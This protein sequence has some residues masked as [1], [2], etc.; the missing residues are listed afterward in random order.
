MSEGFDEELERIKMRMV[1]EMLGGKSRG[2]ESTHPLDLTDEN[3]DQIVGGN[4]LVLVDFWAP[5]CAPCRIVAPILEELAAKYAGK[6]VVGKVNVDENP[7]T[8]MKFMIAAIPT[9]MLFKEGSVV[10]KIVGAV[11]K[12]TL[13]ALIE[14]HLG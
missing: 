11:P 4:R 8:A 7:E 3:F 14:K 10:E 5:W 2:S 12:S 1:R 6:I 13:E 9:I